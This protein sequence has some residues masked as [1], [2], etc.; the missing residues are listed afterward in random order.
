[1]QRSTRRISSH[2][3]FLHRYT[4]ALLF[5]RHVK[6]E[7]IKQAA[8]QPKEVPIGSLS[9]KKC[10][11]QGFRY[12]RHPPV[13]G[14]PPPPGIGASAGM[15][16][17]AGDCAPT[18]LQRNPKCTSPTTCGGHWDPKAADE[19]TCTP[20]TAASPCKCGHARELC[21][22]RLSPRFIDETLCL[23][24]ARACTSL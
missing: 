4:H 13:E 10:K 6:Y 11:V 3:P 14:P 2:L 1:M 18:P 21:A 24:R 12:D 15:S 23:T 9:L 17:T 22:G 5:V 8:T 16:G 20:V 19:S 7:G